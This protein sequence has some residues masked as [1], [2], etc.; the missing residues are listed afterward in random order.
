MNVEHVYRCRI[1]MDLNPLNSLPEAEE[2]QFWEEIYKCAE[3]SNHFESCEM[4]CYIQFEV[5]MTDSTSYKIAIDI[6]N[7]IKKVLK[8]YN[9][10]EVE[11]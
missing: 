3:G 1:D 8:K 11:L 6:H 10:T 2:K 5:L 4:N 9:I 7:L